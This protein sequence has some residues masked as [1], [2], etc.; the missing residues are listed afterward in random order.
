[1]ATR[2]RRAR[3]H[4]TS[5]AAIIFRVVAVLVVAG[6]LV[7]LGGVASGTMVVESWLSDLPDYT[8]PKAFELAEATRVYSADGKLLAKFY[9]EN[10]TIVPMSKISTNLANAVVAIE[11]ER[12]YEHRGFDPLGIARSAVTN[13]QTSDG[14]P[15]GASTITQQYIRNTILSDEKADLTLQRKFREAYLAY[16]VEKR[17]PKDRILEMYM[18]TIYLGEG[19]YGV[20][21]ASR[22]YFSK[23]A[24][25]LSIAEAALLAGLAQRPE[26]WNPYVNPEGAAARRTQVLRQMLDLGFITQEQYVEADAAPVELKRAP[27]PLQGIYS[28]PYFVSHVRKEL[29]NKYPQSVVFK[30]GLSVYTTLD[31]KMQKMAEDAAKASLPSEK[32]PEVALVSI[33]PSSGHV[34]A[35]VGGRDYAKAKYNLATQGRRQPGSSFKTFALVTALKEGVPP[36]TKIDSSSPA[37]L[38]TKPEPWQVS[39]S[40]G[41]GRGNISLES[42]TI[43]SV[44]TVFARLAYKI[45]AGKIADT[46]Q[47]MGITSDVPEYPSIALGTHNVSPLEMASAYGTLATGGIHH[48]PVVITKVVARDD[49]V[50]FEAKPHGKRILD[51]D[52]AGEATDILRRVILSGTARRAQIGRPAAGKT[53]TSQNYRDAWFVGYTPQL[54]TAVWVGYVQ[55]KPMRSVR[56]VRGFGGTL[57][58]PI[59]A[60]YMRSALQGQPSLSFPGHETPKWNP[61]KYSF[62]KAYVPKPKPVAPPS[63]PGPPD[64]EGYGPS[65]GQS[66]GTVPPPPPP[67]DETT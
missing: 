27:Q 50:L 21:A 15:Q 33:D 61:N 46:A 52:I 44:N 22:A 37:V 12:F 60:R 42:A 36:Y 40:E 34:K 62:P 56:G 65:D 14:R 31:T 11:D 43:S 38:S 64:D 63:A 26:G 39:N 3:R 41:R 8:D 6:L 58:A 10:R 55:E 32:D 4:R 18:N 16:E 29:L 23:S 7:S 51:K 19:A 53:G 5:R 57:A 35:L 67:S 25:D 1:V 59:W 13:L 17:Y 49:T 28:S 47:E 24:A 30:G 2:R 48:A 54:V 9:L 66:G 20:E 45:G